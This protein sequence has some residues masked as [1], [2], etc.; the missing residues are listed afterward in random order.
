MDI[1]VHGLHG[2]YLRRLRHNG[3][4]LVSDA[5]VGTLA[6]QTGAWVARTPAGDFAAPIVVNAAGAWA[7]KLAGLAVLPPIGLVPKRRTALIVPPPDLDI[8]AWPLTIDVAENVYFKPEAGKLLV[9]PADETPAAPGDVQPEEIDVAIAPRVDF[10]VIVEADVSN[11][12]D[13]HD[14]VFL[15]EG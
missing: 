9:S 3:G 8:R 14:R 1:D 5:P 13:A 2:A 6:H 10:R 11:E 7:D 15:R 4:R 12:L